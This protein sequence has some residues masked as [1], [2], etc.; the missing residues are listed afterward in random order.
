LPIAPDVTL[1]AFAMKGVATGQGMRIESWGGG[2]LEGAVSGTATIRWG[3]TWSVD[4]VLT[5]RGMNGAV[6]APAL[7][8]EG[9]VEGTGRFS[10]NGPDPTKFMERGR[11]EG[12]FS[13]HKGV[14]GTFDLSRAIQTGGR[15]AAGR[16]PFT[17][18]SAQGLFDKGAIALRNV[19]FSAGAMNAGASADIAA[20]GAL[21]GRV[22]ADIKTSSQ[23]LRAI[24]NLGGTLKEPQVKN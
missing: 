5:I 2:N 14:L 23:T 3:S 4:G 9:K 13:V 18:L 20:D 15:Q 16:T 1:S 12:S 24:V 10:V 6:F 7:L 21:S 17:G 8:S 22:V 19:V 11:L